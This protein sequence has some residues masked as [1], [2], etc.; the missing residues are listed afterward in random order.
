[1]EASGQAKLLLRSGK[2]PLGPKSQVIFRHGAQGTLA[3]QSVQL[4]P[5]KGRWPRV[6]G[7]ISIDAV[8]EPISIEAFAD[9]PRGAAQV[10]S[11]VELDAQGV[12]R[13]QELAIGLTTAGYEPSSDDGE[14]P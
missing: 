9:L 5:E 10:S 11:T 13:F 7:E 4:D 14:T 12:V 1:L 2:V 8:S 6:N 3:L